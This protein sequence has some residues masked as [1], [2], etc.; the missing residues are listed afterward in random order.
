MAHYQTDRDTHSMPLFEFT[1]QLATLE[2]PP[3]ELQHLLGGIHGNQTAM[4][5]FVSIIAGTL[6][7]AEFFDPENISNLMAPPAMTR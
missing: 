4:D 7:P 5:A 6:S 3:P 1:T 2:P